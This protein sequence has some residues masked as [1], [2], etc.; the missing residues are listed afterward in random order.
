MGLARGI[1]Y[2]YNILSKYVRALHF[3]NHCVCVCVV[4]ARFTNIAPPS[5]R[6]APDTAEVNTIHYVIILYTLVIANGLCDID[7]NGLVHFINNNNNYRVAHTDN[8]CRRR[9]RVVF[10]FV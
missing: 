4:F 8:D 3:R 7:D 5:P 2:Y 6:G 1:Y 10:I 9:I